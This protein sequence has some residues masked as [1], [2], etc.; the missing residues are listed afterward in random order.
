ML[1][2]TFTPW[3]KT[4]RLFRDVVITEKLDGTNAAIH[5]ADDGR[6]AAQSRNRLI[7]PDKDNYGFATWVHANAADLAYILG[8]GLHF[9]EWWG[10]G[11]QRR[12][13]LETKRFSLF[14][15][16]RW[17]G[18]EGESDTP[19]NRA[20]QTAL[21]D[22][23]DAVPV[24]YEGP[25]S[26]PAITGTL[27]ILQQKGSHAAPG[28]MNPEGI[29]VFHSQSKNVFKVTLDHNDAAKWEAA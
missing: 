3:P 12:Y 20:V 14:N 10:Q 29:C 2:F 26:E 4:A 22:V 21:R 6:V 11:I 16:A 28:F 7:T 5:V 17:Y 8:P 19:W 23:V 9:G 24:L 18:A 1:E 15:T 13:G 25:F 27:G